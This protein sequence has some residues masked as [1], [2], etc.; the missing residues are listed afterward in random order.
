MHYIPAH[1]HPYYE[2]LGFK[3]NDFPVA[4]KFHQEAISIPVHVLLQDEQ[5]AHVIKILKNI[6]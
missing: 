3:K 6:A 4:E 5:K 2:Q 1:R